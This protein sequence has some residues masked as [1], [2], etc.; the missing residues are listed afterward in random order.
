METCSVIQ[1]GRQWRNLGSLQPPTLRLKQFSCLSFPSSSWDYRC[2]PARPANFCIVGRD[3][4]SLGC[5]AGLKLR[6]SGDL[7][8]LASQS[9]E[10]TGSAGGT[11][12]DE[13]E[14]LLESNIKPSYTLK[15]LKVPLIDLQ[16]CSD[17]Y[18]NESLLHRVELIISEAMICSKLL[19]G[20]M[21]QCTHFGRRR[22]V[23]HLMSRVPDQP[24]QHGET[25][26]LLKIQKLAGHGGGRLCSLTLSPR[27]ECSGAISAYYNLC[28]L[29]SNNSLAS[30]SR[31][32]TFC[33]RKVL[34]R[35]GL[36]AHTCN[37][38]TLG[39]RARQL[40]LKTKKQKTKMGQVWWLMPV[41]P[42]LWEA[43]AVTWK[44][45]A[46]EDHLNVGGRGRSELRLCRCTPAWATKQDSVS[47]NKKRNK[48]NKTQIHVLASLGLHRVRIISIA[49][50][51][52]H[53]LSH[54]KGLTLLC[55][56]ECTVPI[57]AHC[58]LNLSSS[59]GAQWYN[60]SSFSLEL[61]RSSDPPASASRVAGDF[62]RALNQPLL[63]AT[64]RNPRHPDLPGQQ[65]APQIPVPPL[66]PAAAFLL[67]SGPFRR[68]KERS[69]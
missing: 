69:R 25:L 14:Y 5:Q 62:F 66:G 49:V 64:G 48:Q 32:N 16:T 9:A 40:F 41:I 6:I 22:W 67:K 13:P 55:R 45:E 4:V 8:T 57:T 61:L 65:R 21:N 2:T 37:P 63:N 46:G 44:A 19:V 34:F 58:S 30:A 7:P 12:E 18:Q 24:G 59:T 15:E 3:R 68:A 26:S 38:S 56:L 53:I 28:L 54:R 23:D 39:G 33:Y 10:I 1:P 47:K 60:H 20:Q 11:D 29:G 36:V 31:K 50:F 52:L 27:L 43:E 42:A 51:H 17:Y 35:L